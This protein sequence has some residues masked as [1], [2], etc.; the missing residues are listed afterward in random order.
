VL[1]DA[2][3]CTQVPSILS[4][5][6]E[7]LASLT[8]INFFMTIISKHS[9]K[10]RLDCVETR[11]GK[12]QKLDGFLA[13]AVALRAQCA[14]CAS[15]GSLRAIAAGLEERGIPAA[16]GGK[17]SAVQVAR[18]LEADRPFDRRKRGRR[19]IRPKK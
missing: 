13:H 14:P 10:L 11:S 2:Q 7:D 9:D 19:S 8:S 17:C 18:L 15:G 6:A 4:S 12:E 1:H 3:S 5:T 16:L